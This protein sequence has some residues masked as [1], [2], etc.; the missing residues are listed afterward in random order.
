M[1]IDKI[2]NVFIYISETLKYSKIIIKM[3]SQY[4]Y[5]TVIKMIIQYKNIEKSI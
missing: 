3:F 1:N 4:S 2:K 5:I